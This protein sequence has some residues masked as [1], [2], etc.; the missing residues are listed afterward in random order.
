MKAYRQTID[1]AHLCQLQ[2]R[3]RVKTVYGK[4]GPRWDNMVQGYIAAVYVYAPFLLSIFS[5]LQ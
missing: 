5:N 4:F 1:A 3:D 2:T